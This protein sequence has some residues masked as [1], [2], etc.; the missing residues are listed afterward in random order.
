LSVNGGEP[1]SHEAAIK[2]SYLLTCKRTASTS[3]KSTPAQASA[4]TDESESSSDS[5]LSSSDDE[6][7]DKIKK[8]KAQLKGSAGGVPER[9]GGET[10]EQESFAV[11]KPKVDAGKISQPNF[12]AALSNVLTGSTATE[13][14]TKLNAIGKDVL[15]L[16]KQ[17]IEQ[18]AVVLHVMVKKQPRGGDHGDVFQV[19]VQFL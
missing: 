5:S 12:H 14:E 10:E 19:A 2:K 17:L 4:F 18:D 15:N 1:L 9:K 3:F 13:S 11:S 8:E 16:S 6:G 7:K